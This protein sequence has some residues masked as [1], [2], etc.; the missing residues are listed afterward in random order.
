MIIKIERYFQYPIIKQQTP[1]SSMKWKEFTFT[2]EN[3]EECDYLV[4]LDYPKQD[5]SVK[6]NKNNIINL[7]LEPPN[8][9]SLY[10]QYANKKVKIIFNQFDTNN[11]NILSHGALPWHLNKSYDY[12]SS[13]KSEELQKENK[14]TWITS[15]QRSTKGHKDRMDFLD[16][17]NQLEFVNCFGRGINPIEDKF[18]V[19][20]KYKYA[21]AYEN[22]KNDYYWTEKIIDCF[23]SYTMPLYFGCEAIENFFPKNSFIQIDPKDKHIKLFLKEIVSSNKWE[24]N[25]DAI[26]TARDLI[27][28]EYQLYP[29][30]YNKIKSLES[31]NGIYAKQNK[32]IVFIKGT[33]EYFDNYPIQLDILKLYNKAKNKLLKITNIK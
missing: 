24:Q 31:I 23:L 9:I 17:I 8:E 25:I 3:V 11:K 14:I 28:N 21:I 29:F 5:F 33:N 2:E 16:T 32:E 13:L 22:F 4:I 30:L 1:N 19:L 18:E 6:V 10:R 26:N 27:L 15:N 12:L 7:C 20:K